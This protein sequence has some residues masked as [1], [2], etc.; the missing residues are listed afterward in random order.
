MLLGY[1][2]CAPLF[3]VLFL[4]VVPRDLHAASSPD[5]EAARLFRSG[6]YDQ[7]AAAYERL[8]GEQPQNAD[9]AARRIQALLGGNRPK[10]AYAELQRSEPR[11]P[12]QP[13]MAAAAGAVHYRRADFLKADDAF[14]L[15][16]QL[17]GKCGEAWLGLASLAGVFSGF[18]REK[19]FAEIGYRILPEDPRAILAWAPFVVEDDAHLAL[20]KKAFA[21][22]DP[23]AE[24][25]PNLKMAIDALEA[26]GNRDTGRLD[27]AYQSYTFDL[28]ALRNGPKMSSGWGVAARFNGGR[29]LT[30]VVDTGASGIL[31]KRG[32]LR[33]LGLE[34]LSSQ[35][36]Q[37]R[38]VGD[39][40]GAGLTSALA[41]SVEFG[42]LKFRDMPIVV[43]T[44][45]PR[46]DLADGLIGASVF[47]DF[48]VTLDFAQARLRL[49]PLPG[50]K[51]PPP[52][53]EFKDRTIHESE[54]DFTPAY[55]VGRHLFLPVEANGRKS[56]FFLIDSGA[57]TTIFDAEF[58]KEVTAV[59]SDP[60]AQVRGVKGKVTEVMRSSSATLVFAGMR[61]DNDSVVTFDLEKLS[62]DMGFRVSGILGRSVLDL[63]SLTID[64]PNGL[65][66][67]AY[68]QR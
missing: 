18:A 28:I 62:N 56:G 39:E 46:V 16:L 6:L 61:Q 10:E 42:A 49:A 55:R 19:I 58:A 2:R 17:D 27:S 20:L 23:K 40:K 15:A 50:R 35:S 33:Q 25:Y 4:G 11:F 68:R 37:A 65:I 8:A 63:L 31:L 1:L 24:H 44:D 51:A 21:L 52:E 13:A 5:V 22:S 32:A 57:R 14:R 47:K 64:Y 9:Y 29:T 59:S 36:V 60:F 48:L 12:L 67:C 26:V 41:G 45:N 54:R 43:L 7:A 30:L 34:P 3:V 53:A 66:K 38:G